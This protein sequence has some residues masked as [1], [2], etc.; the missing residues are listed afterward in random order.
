MF[1]KI[2]NQANFN[3]IIA[4]IIYWF[5]LIINVF[6]SK[7]LQLE[8]ITEWWMHTT[9]FLLFIT[10]CIFSSRKQIKIIYKLLFI[11][12][13]WLVHAILTIPAALVLGIIMHDVNHIRSA[14]EHRAVFILASLP[15]LWFFIKRS[16]I[17]DNE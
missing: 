12:T 4:F 13:A 8:N 14:G 2:I 15:G 6:I 1:K 3:I 10:L 16:K 9:V 7:K 11:P 5:I 17:F